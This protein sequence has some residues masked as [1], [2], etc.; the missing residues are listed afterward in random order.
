MAVTVAPGMIVT[1]DIWDALFT[2]HGGMP[3]SQQSINV[4]PKPVDEG[5]MPRDKQQP[6]Y[7]YT[8]ADGSTVDARTSPD[9]SGWEIVAYKPSPKFTQTQKQEETKTEAE[10]KPPQERINPEDP[11]RR[12]T[13]NPTARAW[14]D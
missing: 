13:W 5:Y 1:S 4:S 7:R 11:T 6:T 3:N 12:Q 10:A 9:G 14:E 8:L 2:Q